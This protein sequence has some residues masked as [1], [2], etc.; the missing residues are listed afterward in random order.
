M[1]VS[2]THKFYLIDISVSYKDILSFI[3]LRNDYIDSKVIHIRMSKY[4]AII[5]IIAQIRRVFNILNECH[6]YQH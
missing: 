1:F 3:L 5:E 6:V 2:I 4:V